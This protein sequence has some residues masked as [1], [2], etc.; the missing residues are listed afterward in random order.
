MSFHKLEKSSTSE[1]Y[2][3]FD[4]K[5]SEFSVAAYGAIYVIGK[6]TLALTAF[7]LIIN[8]FI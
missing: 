5:T 1:A 2:C 8:G 3:F 6:L 7:P 4:L